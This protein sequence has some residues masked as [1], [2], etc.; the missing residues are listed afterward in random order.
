M[1]CQNVHEK[2]AI[3]TA[4]NYGIIIAMKISISKPVL[5]NLHVPLPEPLYRRLRAG[6]L[7]SGRPATDLAREAIARWLAEEERLRLREAIQAYA[8]GV[9][10]TR[11]DLDPALEAAALE[12]LTDDGGT[13]A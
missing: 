8:R 13:P 11:D 9:A 6:A 7:K 2:Y 10:G 12:H 3:K 1:E 5:K 4:I